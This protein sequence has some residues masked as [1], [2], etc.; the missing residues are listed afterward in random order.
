MGIT[1]YF[2]DQYGMPRYEADDK[3]YWPLGVWL[4]SEL[5]SNFAAVLDALDSIHQALEGIEP[6]EWEGESV[7]AKFTPKELILIDYDGTEARY[8]MAEA[9]AE[10]E[11]YWRFLLGRSPM[12]GTQRLLRPDLPEHEAY[13]LQWEQRWNKQHPY[14]GKLEGIP[15]EGPR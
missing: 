1:R 13:L 8:P 7:E 4:V 3:A 9:R 5:R 10:V 2:T 14:R 6:E 12:P 15:A 11:R